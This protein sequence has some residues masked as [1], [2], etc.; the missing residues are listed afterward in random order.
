[1]EGFNVLNA[2]IIVKKRG[3][4]MQHCYGLKMENMSK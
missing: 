3:Q 4:T 2:T 1:M